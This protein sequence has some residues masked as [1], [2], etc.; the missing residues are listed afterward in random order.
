MLIL[1]RIKGE[2]LVIEYPNGE[3]VIIEVVKVKKSS[4]DIGTDAPE[5]ILVLRKE[6]F[7][8][9]TFTCE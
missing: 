3:K 1:T 9:Q 5:H 8:E 6:K 2:R 4:V 7:S